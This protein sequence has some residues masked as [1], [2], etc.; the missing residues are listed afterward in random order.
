MEIATYLVI[1]AFGLLYAA[2]DRRIQRLDRRTA[3][4]EHQLDLDL[5]HLGLRTA[6]PGMERVT[7]LLRDGKKIEAIK[8]YREL[9]DAG[10]KDAKEAVERMDGAA[11]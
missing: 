9:T 1:V 5:D 11:M 2:L 8:V 3:R 10:L 6:Q 7:A 4:M